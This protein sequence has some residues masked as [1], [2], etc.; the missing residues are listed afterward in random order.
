MIIRIGIPGSFKRFSLSNI[1]ENKNMQHDFILLD[2]SSSMADLWTEALGSVNGY[3][4]KLAEDNVDTGVTLAMFDRFNNEFA[5]D[6]IRDRI[7]PNTWRDVTNS[8]AMPRGFTP[9]SDAIG[10]IVAQANAGN[11]DKVAI[12]VMTDGEENASHELSV[13]QAKRLLDD[14]R[15]KGWQVIWLGANFDNAKQAASY[16]TMTANTIQT[17]AKNIGATM[18]ATASLRARYGAT[19]QSMDYTAEQQRTFKQ[20]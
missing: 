8:D 19:G 17:S 15:T 6:I 12:I 10:C 5:F 2:R 18:T 4:K 14:C 13:P 9:L 11:Y 1:V 7:A 16:G 3:V 20:D